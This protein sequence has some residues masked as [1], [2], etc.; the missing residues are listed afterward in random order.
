MEIKNVRPGTR[1]CRDVREIYEGAFKAEERLPL[2]RMLLLNLLRPSVKLQAY[3]EGDT[4]CGFTFVVVTDCYLYVDYL[5]INP[6]LRGKGYG[7]RIMETLLGSFPVP[8]IGECL[9]PVP[10]DPH[11]EEDL[12]RVHFWEKAGFQFFD[13]QLK[14]TGQGRTYL[15]NTTGS[16]NRDDYFACFDHLSFGPEAF[17]R[18]MKRKISK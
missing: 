11:Y 2:S 9:E 18:R 15:V 4:F 17:L 16:Y 13:Y 8:G 1:I 10:G 5:V 7:S 3:Y 6:A 14:N 12:A